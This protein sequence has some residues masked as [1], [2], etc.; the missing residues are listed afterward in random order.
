MAKKIF[1][2]YRYQLLPLNNIS[3]LIYTKEE[4]IKNKNLFFY[5]ALQDLSHKERSQKRIYR[6][7]IIDSLDQ[8]FYMIVDKKIDLNIVLED[9]SHDKI[10]TYPYSNIFIDNNKETQ[11]IAIE[12]LSYLKP[13]NVIK[14]FQT[15]LNKKLYEKG[16]CIKIS[17]IYQKKSFWEFVENN[18]DSIS[19]VSFNIITPNMSSISFNLNEEIKDI[20][21]EIGAHETKLS[22]KAQ[23]G[24]VLH[25]QKDNKTIEGLVDYS[26]QGGGRITVNLQGVKISF[27]T[28]NQQ[29]NVE[30]D[31]FTGSIDDFIKLKESFYNGNNNQ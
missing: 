14:N 10:P 6:Y 26:S 1:H 19:K 13:K 23:A 2:F 22:L 17:Q 16:L 4:L 15:N 31:N 30:I 20:A 18:H 8:I 7:E 27:D 24:E 9:H 25:L 29:Y 12:Y 11:L 5:E 3:R 28:N 21:K